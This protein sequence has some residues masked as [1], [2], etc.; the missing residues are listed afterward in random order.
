MWYISLR[1]EDLRASFNPSSFVRVV[2]WRTFRW[3]SRV[4]RWN[5]NRRNAYEILES[6]LHRERQSIL[7]VKALNLVVGRTVW[8]RSWS[9]MFVSK[10]GLSGWLFQFSSSLAVVVPSN[11]AWNVPF[12]PDGPFCSHKARSSFGSKPV[13][14]HLMC[15]QYASIKSPQ[16]LV[17]SFQT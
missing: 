15:Q 2:T 5:D 14:R 10:S 16:G 7:H 1:S 3:I 9:Q 11:H 4:T 13:L 8:V 12:K 17:H 6:S